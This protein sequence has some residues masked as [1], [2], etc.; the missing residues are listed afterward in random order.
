MTKKEY[1]KRLEDLI[2]NRIKYHAPKGQAQ[3][4][5]LG[6]LNAYGIDPT[7]PIFIFK[8][9]LDQLFYNAFLS[10]KKHAK[11]N[12]ILF[13]NSN[14]S[15]R[16]LSKLDMTYLI[17]TEEIGSNLYKT[18]ESLNVNYLS[19]STFKRIGESEYL[20]I[21]EQ[22]LEFKYMPYYLTNKIMKNGI[23]IDAKSFILNGKNY[24]LTFSNPNDTGAEIDFE[25]NLPLPRGYYS[26]KNDRGCVSIKNLTNMQKAY[27]NY[28]SPDCKF[29]FSNVEGIE[30]SSFACI[31][32]F[33]KIK[34]LSKETKTIFF[35]FGDKRMFVGS[36][37]DIL[38]LF[39]I[40]QNKT[41]EIF[42]LQVI[43]HDKK[44]DERFNVIL[45]R[46][47]WKKWYNFDFDQ[48][49]ENEWIKLKNSL[50][51]N[52]DNGK[53]INHERA[54]IKVIKFFYKN[55]W[56]KVFV[57]HN[58]SNYMYADN[59]KYFNYSLLTKDIFEK[60]NEIY[61]SFSE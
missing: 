29:Q 30:S 26:F 55:C 42:D 1:V 18:L 17:D 58:N 27:F 49:S 19:H 56:K 14:L 39:Q 36:K 34:L 45:P 3:N 6:L 24:F 47:I 15:K 50:V 31:H 8:K 60:N 23:I 43:T 5:D 40:S 28:F 61:L 11:F 16:K 21:N 44:F 9:P 25:L 33:A 4:I 48:E 7:Y 41:N 59:I 38:N 20:K 52:F 37:K 12:L 32:I 51:I 35:N 10:V 22:K 57:V 46:N 2:F 54:D 13:S 53:Q